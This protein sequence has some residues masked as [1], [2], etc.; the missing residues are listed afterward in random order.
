MNILLSAYSCRPGMGSEPGVG[1]NTARELAQHL[2]VWVLTRSDNRPMIEAELAQNPIPGIRFIYF[3]L[4]GVYWWKKG[5]QGVHIHYY[6]WQVKAYFVARQLHQEI[7]IDIIHHVTYV[8]YSSPSFLALLPIPFVWGPVGGGESAPKEFWKDFSLR[9]KTYELL[10]G[11]ARYL[12]EQDPFVRMTARRSCIAYGT[13][14][15]TAHRLL[16][17]GSKNVQVLS[18]VGLSPEEVEQLTQ[19]PLSQEVPMR[20]LSIGRILHWK[21]FQLGLRAFAQASLPS[22]AEYWIVG[23]GSEKAALQSL[24]KDLGIASQ[25]KFF[26]EM[27]RPDLLD[28]LGSC[29]ALVHPSLHESGGFICLEAMAAG[30]P[31]ICLDLGG[32]ASQVTIETGFKIAPCTPEQAISEIAEVMH[33]LTKEPALRMK[34]GQCGQSH[35]KKFYTWNAKTLIFSE[36]YQKL[37]L[38]DA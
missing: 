29:L 26:S 14:D 28:Q 18:Q 20:F 37:L 23:N 3:D 30:C 38:I 9:G 22:E 27:P 1:W 34:L 12:G 17:I 31:V 19:S 21:G 7:G 15:D 5:L 8:R 2:K 24:V 4:P 10:R 6:L 36:M 13:T 33:R 11:W 35:V 16:A 32:P 25:V